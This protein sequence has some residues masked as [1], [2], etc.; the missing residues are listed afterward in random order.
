MSKSEKRLQ[1]EAKQRELQEAGLRNKIMQFDI[2]I[3]EL[4]EEI[5]RVEKNKRLSQ[6]ALDKLLNPV[7]EDKEENKEGDS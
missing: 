1:I 3:L 6:E 4:E 2:K 7:V 5:E